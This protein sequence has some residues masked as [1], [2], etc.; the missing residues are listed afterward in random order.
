M[1]TPSSELPR[2]RRILFLTGTRADFGKLKPL[3]ARVDRAPEFECDIFA[4]GMHNLRRYGSTIHEIEKC[5]FTN[6]FPHMNQIAGG[7]SE[8]DLVLAETI[9]GLGHYVR[10]RPP[11]LIVVHGDRVETLAAAI[12]GAMNNVLVAHIEGGER[13]G[14]V[15]ELIRHSVSKL[16]HLHFVANDE[17]RVRLLQMGE[18]EDSVFLIG[19]PDIDVMNSD[20]LPSLDDVRQRYQIPFESY[21]IFLYHPVTTELAELPRR[22]AEITGALRE[23]GWNFVVLYPN[24]DRGADTIL[25][26]I[27][28]LAA[29]PRFRVFPSLRFEHF[30]TLLKH[31]RALVGNSSAGIREAPAYCVP[32]IN[33][34]SRQRGRFDY[35]SIVNVA[36]SRE[37][38]LAALAAPPR[39][40]TP[41]RHFGG[42]RERGAL[43]GVPP[44]G[45]PVGDQLP[46]T[47]SGHPRRAHLRRLRAARL[48]RAREASP[49]PSS[50][51]RHAA[52]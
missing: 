31:A 14:T 33:L 8:M 18:R 44:D 43:H 35:P 38:V 49:S 26:A 34:G 12:V 51:R 41:S 1:S 3:M 19:S 45:R 5:G 42:R 39:T 7:T 37:S 40:Q 27:G 30:L 4:T 23:S 28:P 25:D 48:R 15:D 52:A 20:T 29:E 22:A 47:V 50:S 9:R 2:P 10:E 24:S 13:S 21:G 6:I 36:E 11:D 16:A 46:E 17:A 32:T